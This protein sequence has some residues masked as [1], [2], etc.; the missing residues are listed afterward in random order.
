MTIDEAKAFISKRRILDCFLYCDEC[1]N[2][3]CDVYKILTMLEELKWYREQDLVRREDRPC[4]RIFACGMRNLKNYNSGV[5]K[6]SNYTGT[7]L[8]NAS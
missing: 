1:A 6:P 3:G 8:L 7:R 2:Y 4:E 5:G